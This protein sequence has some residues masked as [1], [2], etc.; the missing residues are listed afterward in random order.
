[1]IYKLY[2]IFRENHYDILSKNIVKTY[3]QE[4]INEKY[5]NDI[6]YIQKN[7]E[8]QIKNKNFDKNDSRDK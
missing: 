8:I 4:K 1:M 3:E 2:P 5:Y 6:Q 7:L